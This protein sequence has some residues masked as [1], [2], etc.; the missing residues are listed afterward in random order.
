MYNPFKKLSIADIN[1]FIAEEYFYAAAQHYRRAFPYYA[2]HDKTGLLLT[3]Y[4]YSSDARQHID[5]LEDQR[6]AA[7][8]YLNH[9]T[10]LL[11]LQSMLSVSSPYILFNGNLKDRERV[12][13]K[14]MEMFKPQ[15]LSY[16][17]R[18]VDID[19]ATDFK[20]P[21]VLK[22]IYGELY[23]TIGEG[24]GKQQIKLDII[25]NN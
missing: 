18:E 5:N 16:L 6:H 17:N 20:I 11:R 19:I 1:A 15:L 7:I 10:H 9:E 13:K 24:F 25:E 3:F 14:D 23:I 22:I 12:L 8:I 21:P 2:A 4:K